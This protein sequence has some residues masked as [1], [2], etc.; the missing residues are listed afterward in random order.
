MKS[1]II[2]KAQKSNMMAAKRLDKVESGEPL[3]S[4][5]KALIRRSSVGTKK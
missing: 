4:K 2:E 5:Q 3:S 1:N